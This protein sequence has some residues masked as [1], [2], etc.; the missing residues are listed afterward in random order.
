MK[1]KIKYLIWCFVFLLW[2]LVN[3]SFWLVVEGVTLPLLS[4]NYSNSSCYKYTFIDDWIRN[5]DSSYGWFWYSL[6]YDWS[7]QYNNIW[8]L[9]S[10]DSTCS[11]IYDWLIFNN[12]VFSYSPYNWSCYQTC[13]Q[14]FCQWHFV[15]YTWSL[16]WINE[17]VL[18]WVWSDFWKIFIS[19]SYLSLT[20]PKYSLWWWYFNWNTFRYL[21]STNLNWSPIRVFYNQNINLSSPLDSLDLFSWTWSNITWSIAWEYFTVNNAVYQSKYQDT[22]KYI[23]DYWRE[24]N[25]W[26]HFGWYGMWYS[27]AVDFSQDNSTLQWWNWSFSN[28]WSRCIESAINLWITDFDTLTS[29]NCSSLWL[30]VLKWDSYTSRNNNASVIVLWKNPNNTKQILYEQFDCAD[31]D[32]LRIMNYETWFCNSMSHWF[33]TYNWSSDILPF[34]NKMD[35]YTLWGWNAFLDLL[36][37]Q[38]LYWNISIN[39][40]SYC[41]N[42][43]SSSFCFSLTATPRDTSL[44]EYYL[45]AWWD[46]AGNWQ[47]VWWDLLNDIIINEPS[48]YYTYSWL[49]D[50][51]MSWL[52]D[53][54]VFDSWYITDYL[55]VSTWN[56]FPTLKNI[57][58]W[59][60]PFSDDWLF[61]TVWFEE[62]SFD[63]LSPFKCLLYS[64]QYWAISDNRFPILYKYDPFI[65]DPF[66]CNFIWI[67]LIFWV[68]KL[69]FSIVKNL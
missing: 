64:F 13:Y 19:N 20:Y 36:F 63:L 60:C 41:L 3:H 59:V 10:S 38:W 22:S 2:L 24:W 54:I 15:N 12:S 40:D 68:I 34:E 62:F 56:I 50:Y 65:T 31:D 44:K 32:I 26:L 11:T 23:I 66:L 46:L 25:K 1:I 16:S 21:S 43:S 28:V 37:K 69:I 6:Y 14:W 5:W 35:T 51:S 58:F 8:M 42:S 48:S 27:F 67:I 52:V 45:Q 7:S 53:S 57:R 49:L 18:L 47:T 33:I 30:L 29:N 61:P 4:T 55:A 17:Y 39:W 9:N